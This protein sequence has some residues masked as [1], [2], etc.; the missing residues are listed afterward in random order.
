MRTESAELTMSIF[1]AFRVASS[2]ACLVPVIC[3]EFFSHPVISTEPF[4]FST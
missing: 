4:R 3:T 2:E 1:S